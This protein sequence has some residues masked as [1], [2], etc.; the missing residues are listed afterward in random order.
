MTLRAPTRRP[1]LFRY[2]KGWL[3]TEPNETGVLAPVLDQASEGT[4]I[5]IK[6]AAGNFSGEE[7]LAPDKMIVLYADVRFELSASVTL[8]L[9]LH[10]T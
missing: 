9:F 6:D 1:L 3:S 7:T 5:R 2:I 10:P 4:K 8:V